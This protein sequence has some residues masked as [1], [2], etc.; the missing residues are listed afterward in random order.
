MVPNSSSA[1][2]LAIIGEGMGP[3]VRQS[4]RGEMEGCGC[5]VGKNGR[6]KRDSQL[7]GAE[8]FIICGALRRSQTY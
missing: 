3:R 8:T 1:E 6:G 7:A 4:H 2:N 5:D